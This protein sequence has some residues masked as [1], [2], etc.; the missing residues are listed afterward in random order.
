M[1]GPR[2][3]TGGAGR[4][5]AGAVGEMLAVFWRVHVAG[6]FEAEISERPDYRLCIDWDGVIQETE[7]LSGSSMSTRSPKGG[8][9][10]AEFYHLALP[11]AQAPAHVSLGRFGA[12]QSDQA[13]LLTGRWSLSAAT[14]CRQARAFRRAHQMRVSA[15]PDSGVGRAPYGRARL[16]RRFA[17]RRVVFGQTMA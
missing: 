7:E 10:N 12:G 9:D 3:P 2:T 4:E 8:L 16:A 6:L 14:P 1:G 15:R 17:T 11:Q 5:G 13:C